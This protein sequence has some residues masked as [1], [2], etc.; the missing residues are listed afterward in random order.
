VFTLDDGGKL[1]SC[2]FE[3]GKETSMFKK[4]IKSGIFAILAGIAI[5]VYHTSG[6]AAEDPIPTIYNQMGTGVVLVV[7]G[8]VIILLMVF[9]RK[10]IKEHEE[11]SRE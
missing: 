2:L 8:I 1:H 5:I 10:S 3:E 6:A 9:G 7:V 11:K 4:G